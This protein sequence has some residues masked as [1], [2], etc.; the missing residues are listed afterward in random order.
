[1]THTSRNPVTRR[2]AAVIKDLKSRGLFDGTLV[3]CGSE[4]GRTPVCDLAALRA[5]CRTGG[6]TTRSASR[7]GWPARA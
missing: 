6:I 3:I 7:R 4:F 1:M 2:E 5:R